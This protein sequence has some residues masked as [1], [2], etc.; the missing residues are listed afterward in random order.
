MTQALIHECC[1]RSMVAWTL[2]MW[3]CTVRVRVKVRVKVEVRVR[4]RVRV[5]AMV[6]VMVRVRVKVQAGVRVRG[7]VRG[8][9]VNKVLSFCYSSKGG[10]QLTD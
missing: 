7:R 4:V 2:T 1:I 10:D 9:Q 3:W 5:R 6:M 8:H